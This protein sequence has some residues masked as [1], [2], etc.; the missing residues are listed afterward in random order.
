MCAVTA[1]L[2]TFCTPAVTRGVPGAPPAP[3]STTA[4]PVIDW[5]NEARRAIVPAGPGGIFGPENYGNKFPGEAAVYIAIVHVAIYDAAVAIAGSYRPYAAAID[6]PANTSP[7]AAIATAAHHVLIGLQPAL[8]LTPQQQATLDGNYET[9]LQQIPEGPAKTNGITVGDQVATAV[10]ALRVNDGRERNPQLGDLG[11]PPSGPGV[12]DAGSAAAVGLRMPAIVPLALES[13]AQFRPD[14]PTPLM[15][16]DYAR[17]FKQVARLGSADSAARTA[18]QTAAALFWTDHDLRQ[19]NDGML[20]LASARGLDLLQ[21]ARMLAMAHVAGGDAMI[22]CFDAK[23]AY[24]FWRPDQAVPRADTDG[25]AATEAD[26]AWQPLRATPNFPE[27]PSAH[28]CHTTAVAE[29]LDEFFGTNRVRFSLDS[30]ITGTTREYNRLHEVVADVDSARVLVGFHFRNSDQ[31]GTTLGRKVARYVIGHFFL[32]VGSPEGLRY[33]AV[34]SNVASRTTL[35]PSRPH[36]G[37]S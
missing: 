19:W 23:Y 4:S 16:A 18:A 1:S 17:D 32:R 13:G 3:A 31:E 27:Y 12:W 20:R 29:A 25:N 6:A 35:T 8:G 2:L 24:W 22:A 5:S 7:E 30:R 36:A 10:L 21:T 15:G 28:A 37:G 33:K 11:P 9:Y 14:G 34:S 26:S